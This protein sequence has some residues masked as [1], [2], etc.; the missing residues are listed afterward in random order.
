MHIP[1]HIKGI[2]WVHRDSEGV[3]RV[4]RI[5]EGH[6]DRLNPERAKTITTHP[7]FGSFLE[8]EYVEF[9]CECC[10]KR[11]LLEHDQYPYREEVIHALAQKAVAYKAFMFI[12]VPA[13]NLKTEDIRSACEEGR[14]FTYRV[15]TWL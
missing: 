3:I 13:L 14:K 12:S 7:S 8:D 11:M 1:E 15:R 9:D 6:Q 10:P 5:P 4:L 2:L